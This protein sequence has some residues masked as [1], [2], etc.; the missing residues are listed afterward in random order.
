M[1]NRLDGDPLNILASRV[2]G[3]TVGP[4]KGVFPTLDTVSLFRAD[5]DIQTK[6]NV[7]RHRHS[8]LPARHWTLHSARHWT[9]SLPSRCRT[10]RKISSRHPTLRP[11]FMG[12]NSVTQCYPP[13]S[14]PGATTSS[15]YYHT[16]AR[17]RT[18]TCFLP[19]TLRAWN[20]L[21]QV[22][23]EAV[24]LDQFKASLPGATN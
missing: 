9:L 4:M 8:E 18:C 17:T 19:V 12:P 24:T 10:L 20:A 7:G 2:P 13:Q 23:L 1:N 15:S 21:P 5:T 3:P 6:I 16:V 14:I 22:A 11:P